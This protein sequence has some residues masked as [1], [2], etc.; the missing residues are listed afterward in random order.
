MVVKVIEKKHDDASNGNN[1]QEDI[2]QGDKFESLI[3]HVCFV[4]EAI[5]SFCASIN[6]IGT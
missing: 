6:P 3:C 4:L 1:V 2:S 5:N